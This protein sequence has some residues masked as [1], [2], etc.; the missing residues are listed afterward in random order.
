MDDWLC[1]S[2]VHFWTFDLDMMRRNTCNVHMVF[3][4]NMGLKF[5]D[6]VYSEDIHFEPKGILTGKLSNENRGYFLWKMSRLKRKWS[7]R[8]RPKGLWGGSEHSKG[9]WK[10]TAK[11]TGSTWK[12]GIRE[13]KRDFGKRASNC[14]KS[15]SISLCYGRTRK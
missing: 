5:R 7:L 2:R 6:V 4:D 12:W 3:V 10:G 13:A 8:P 11:G 14:I 9:D 15:C 1:R